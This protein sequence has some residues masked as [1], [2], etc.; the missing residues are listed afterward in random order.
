[1]QQFS[2]DFPFEETP[3]QQTAIASVIADMLADKPMDR[4]V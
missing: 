1:M 2:A 3:D 4:L